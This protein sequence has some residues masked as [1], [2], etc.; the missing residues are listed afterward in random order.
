[1]RKVDEILHEWQQMGYDFPQIANFVQSN[2]GGLPEDFIR[3][4]IAH[5]ELKIEVP[6][7]MI[8]TPNTDR[9]SDNYFPYANEALSEADAIATRVRESKNMIMRK[10]EIDPTML[11]I[12][13]FSQTLQTRTERYK[14]LLSEPAQKRIDWLQATADDWWNELKVDCDKIVEEAEERLRSYV[15]ALDDSWIEPWHQIPIDSI[16]GVFPATK[17]QSAQDRRDA[18]AKDK[19]PTLSLEDAKKSF[20]S[21]MQLMK[22]GWRRYQM[23]FSE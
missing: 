1:M 16:K 19:A 12:C 13:H 3:Y 2:L 8:F 4:V 9:G 20:Q 22:D 10:L 18:R 23:G 14:P 11:S 17:I 7:E 15:V 5:P 21:R 6:Q